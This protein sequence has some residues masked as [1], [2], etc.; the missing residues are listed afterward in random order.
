MRCENSWRV[1][2]RRFDPSRDSAVYRHLRLGTGF[3]GVVVALRDLEM[4]LLA[5]EA[6]PRLARARVDEIATELAP[7]IADV[8]LVLSELVTN[9][10]RHSTNSEKIQVRVRVKEEKILLEVVDSGPGFSQDPEERGDGLGLSIV[11]QLADE[12]GVHTNDTCTVWVEMTR[13]N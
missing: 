4:E 8:K 13:S 10:V 1:N 7:R 6:A 12:W 9:S 2:L 5:D 3:T 11:G